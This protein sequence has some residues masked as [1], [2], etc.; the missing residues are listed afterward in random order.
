MTAS[1]TERQTGNLTQERQDLLEALAQ[2]RY[3]LRQTTDGLTDRQADHRSTVSE[4]NLGGLIKH[5]AD[6]EQGWAEFVVRGP[7]AMQADDLEEAWSAHQMSFR[8]QEGQTLAGL[9]AHYEAVAQQTDELVRTVDLD[10]AHALPEAP[11]FEP[12]K[13]WTNRR[14][15]AHIIAET[16]Q[17]AG[18]ADIIREAIDGKKSMG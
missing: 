8:M 2:H 9:L 7:V 6:G 4:L 5:V 14:V 1:M 16:A 13:T 12:G 10:A 3:F 17:H 18:H 15:F 11:W